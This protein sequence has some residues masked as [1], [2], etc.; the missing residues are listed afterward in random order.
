MATEIAKTSSPFS[1]MFFALNVL[2]AGERLIALK[3]KVE[4]FY[5]SYMISNTPIPSGTD[6]SVPVNGTVSAVVHQAA[7]HAGVVL[8]SAWA[9][10]ASIGSA[11]DRTVGNNIPLMPTILWNQ[12]PPGFKLASGAL[13]CFLLFCLWRSSRASTIKQEI[14]ITVDGVKIPVPTSG[15]Q[16]DIRI[17][18]KKD[19]PMVSISG[20]MYN[21]LKKYSPSSSRKDAPLA[22]PANKE[23]V[24]IPQ[25]DYDSLLSAW[26]SQ[27]NSLASQ[28]QNI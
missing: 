21:Q 12:I 17:H 15:A 27:T 20:G 2:F 9:Q 18:V 24:I 23:N 1:T 10:A 16:E 8:N 14:N 3:S 28:H 26:R 6:L 4:D 13:A 25:R 7:D 5:Q 11:V 19:D 22:D